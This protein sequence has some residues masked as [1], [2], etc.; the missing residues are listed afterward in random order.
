[1]VAWRAPLDG[2]AAP[3]QLTKQPTYVPTISHNGSL[4][5]AMQGEGSAT[6]YKV[7]MIIMPPSGEPAIHE[8]D[9]LPTRNSKF[10]FT[11]DDKSVAYTALDDQGVA[12][13][14]SQSLQGGAPKKITGFKSDNIFD[15]AWS[16]DGKQLAVSRGRTSRDVVLLTDTANGR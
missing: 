8:F 10:A 7:K 16:P 6:T 15:F 9:M 2:A 1:M 11:P 14:W 4:I 12:N 3:Q 5:A 13:I